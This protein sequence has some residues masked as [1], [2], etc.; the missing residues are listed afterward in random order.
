MHT[1]PASSGDVRRT[2]R[3]QVAVD[4]ELHVVEAGLG[5]PLLLL[6]GFPDNGDLWQPLAMALQ[7]THRLWMPDLRGYRHSDKP[8]GVAS[9]GIDAL[10]EDVRALC[11]AMAGRSPGRVALAGHDWG[12]LLA[13]VFAARHPER[14]ERLIV[15]NVPHPQRLA[16]LLRDDAAQREASS[17]M[18]RLR[19]PGAEAALA[20]D[21]CARLRALMRHSL[22]D[23]AAAEL[24]ALAAGWSAPGALTAMLNWYRANAVSDLARCCGRI[25]APTLLLWGEQEGSFVPANLERL[26][27]LVPRLAL[28]R[29]ADA[30]HWLPRQR[31]AE[32]AQAM[33]AFLQERG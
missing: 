4:V 5:A 33:I 22:P 17:Y 30:G 32:V 8:A 19:T 6:H 25:E 7:A 23:L 13:W 12:G 28:R 1:V 24:D 15:C 27:R 9:Y 18:D 10:L 21:D 31:P 26:E 3:L 14:V 16:E 29:F 20:A 2:L 11:D